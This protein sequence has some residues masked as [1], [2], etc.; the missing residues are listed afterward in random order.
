MKKYLTSFLLLIVPVLL[1]AQAPQGLNYQAVAYNGSGVPVT[2][3]LLG[4]RLSILDGSATGTLV[5][6]ETQGP[7]TDNTGLFSIVIGNGTVV[8]GTFN[9]INWGN[10]SKWLKTEIDITGGTSY[11]VMGTTQFLSVPYS[12]YADKAGNAGATLEFPDGLENIEPVVLDTVNWF[13]VPPGKN[14]YTNAEDVKI[15]S[16]EYASG[17]IWYPYGKHSSNFIGAGPN[18]QVKANLTGFLVNKKV[19]W[20]S[21]NIACNTLTV[22]AGKIFV[23]RAV[24]FNI[25]QPNLNWPG[26]VWPHVFINGQS[27]EANNS[28]LILKAGDILTSN[29]PCSYGYYFIN[30]YFKDK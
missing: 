13:I 12:F 4:V 9:T 20:I 7:T 22:P 2:N 11:V 29:M 28:F 14:L 24:S 3:Q 30:G 18:M 23:L 5:Y 15:D 25:F 27:I 17:D 26:N 8:S 10:G 6:Q 21:L 16:S 1:F 19:D